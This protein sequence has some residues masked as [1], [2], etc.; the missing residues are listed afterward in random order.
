MARPTHALIDCE[1]LKNNFA[2]A[3]SA[4]NGFCMPIVKANAYGHGVD[5]VCNTLHT[6]PAFGVASIDEALEL[7]KLSIK[8]PILLLEGTFKADEIEVA[9]AENMWL[10]VENQQQKNQI[11]AASV[12]RPLRIWLGLDTGMH[13]LGFQPTEIND[14]YHSLSASGKID[15]IAVLATHF[16]YANDLKHEMTIQQM[17]CFDQTHTKIDVPDGHA[18]QQSLANSAAILGWPASLRDWQRPGYLLYGNSPISDSEKS[19]GLTPVMTFKSA[20]ISIRT[21][22]AGASVGYEAAWT[23]RRDS[24]IATISVGYGDGYPRH[25]ENGTPVLVGNKR[26]PLVGRV[27]MDM[28]TVD[29]TDCESTKIGDDATLWGPQ[30]PVNEVAQHCNTNG[31]ELLSA[32]TSRVPRIVHN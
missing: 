23:A 25:A 19:Y 13:R 5:N 26:C 6:A 32:V 30:L 3:E 29:V 8:Q 18:L 2:L 15:R 17:E 11:L 27:S 14:V 4:Q 12:K 28:I 16:A 7:R 22:K 1:A 20:I 24:I 10:M 21:I 31:Y 9:S